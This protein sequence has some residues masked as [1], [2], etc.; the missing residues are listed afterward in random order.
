MSRHYRR[1]AVLILHDLDLALPSLS[2][3]LA[4]VD[5][6]FGRIGITQRRSAQTFARVWREIC[7]MF[8]SGS[9]SLLGR[10]ETYRVFLV[11]LSTVLRRSVQ[12]AEMIPSDAAFLQLATQP[13]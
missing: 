11:E 3:T 1:N 10:L 6:L 2:R 8:Q 4:D 12:L 13:V 5:R 9:R 7:C